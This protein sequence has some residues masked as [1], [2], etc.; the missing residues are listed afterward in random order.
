MSV[1]LDL[2]EAV[3]T[4]LQART[5]LAGI[6]VIID[7]QKDLAGDI[8]AAIAKAS[9]CIVIYPT[10]GGRDP[11]PQAGDEFFAGITVDVICTPLLQAAGAVAADDL[12]QDVVVALDGWSRPTA[13]TPGSADKLRVLTFALDPDPNYLVW[14][15]TARTRLFFPTE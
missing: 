6:T 11:S 10:Q 13:P 2:C 9:A 3:Q 15:I 4:R 8:A 1:M 7:R 5:A 14:Q 12:A